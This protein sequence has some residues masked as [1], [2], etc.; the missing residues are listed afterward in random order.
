VRF[1][2]GSTTV[3]RKVARNSLADRAHARYVLVLKTAFWLCSSALKKQRKLLPK[4]V[5]RLGRRLVRSIQ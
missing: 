4:S 1:V 2:V 5:E 3:A